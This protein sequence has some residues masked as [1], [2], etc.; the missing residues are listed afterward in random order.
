MKKFIILDYYADE[1]S[2]MGDRKLPEHF[3]VGT[4]SNSNICK[5]SNNLR[6]G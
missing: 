1:H 2:K 4:A 5:D 6:R 3:S